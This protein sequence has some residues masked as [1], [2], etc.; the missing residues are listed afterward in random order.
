MLTTPYGH[1]MQPGVHCL[2]GCGGDMWP[3]PMHVWVTSESTG[4]HFLQ[5]CMDSLFGA[6]EPPQGAKAVE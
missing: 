3:G 2:G 5:W 1:A 6:S 4:H